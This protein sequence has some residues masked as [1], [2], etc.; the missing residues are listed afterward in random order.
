MTLR[1]YKD[2]KLK[3]EVWTKNLEPLK[4]KA[5]C[6]LRNAWSDLKCV[7]E[8]TLSEIIILFCIWDHN[9][10]F[11]KHCKVRIISICLLDDRGL[12]PISRM[13]VWGLLWDSYFWTKAVKRLTWK[14]DEKHL[15]EVLTFP[16]TSRAS[17]CFDMC[18]RESQE[19]LDN[20][21]HVSL[22]KA[23]FNTRLCFELY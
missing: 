12:W 10:Q 6:I 5:N 11:W 21:V 17:I 3:F 16:R 1:R 4:M 18:K 19:C 22:S 9:I 2:L 20:T 7:Y 23:R 8:W 13:E 14:L 15:H